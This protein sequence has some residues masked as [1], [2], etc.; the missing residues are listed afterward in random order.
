MA[1]KPEQRARRK[2]D[3]MLAEAGWVI[4]DRAEAGI[5]VARG[6]AI[7]EFPLK[8]GS[9]FAD[10]L[11]YV[12]AAAAGVVEALEE[13]MASISLTKL[14]A[15][16]IPVVSMTE[17]E[18]IVAE[19]ERLLSVTDAL[20]R[21]CEAN[22]KRA[23]RLRQAILKKAFEG[24]LV[25]QHPTDESAS[26]ILARLRSSAPEAGATVANGRKSKVATR[27]RR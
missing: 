3:R 7:R 15:F 9:G 25:P 22:T 16:P 23:E 12:D 5:T 27:P 4:Q 18:R 20:D 10:Y 19:L 26:E 13:G 2:I 6:V 11:L 8:P 17:Q 21:T 1:E 24:R 14:R